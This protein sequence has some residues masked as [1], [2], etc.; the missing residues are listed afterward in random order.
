MALIG[1]LI[2]LF[3]KTRREKD[4]L[5]SRKIDFEQINLPKTIT[6][7]FKWVMV[8]QFCDLHHWHHIGQFQTFGRKNVKF[9]NFQG[10][11]MALWFSVENKHYVEISSRLRNCMISDIFVNISTHA[12]CRRIK[13]S[14]IRKFWMLNHMTVKLFWNSKIYIF[15]AQSLKPTIL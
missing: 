6:H 7:L 1:Q 15:S 9:S 5:I 10:K 4:K 11:I 12:M 13:I 8:S 2:F 3:F 14:V